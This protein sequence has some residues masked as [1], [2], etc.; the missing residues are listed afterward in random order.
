[1]SDRAGL[2]GRPA[3]RPDVGTALRRGAGS[4]GPGTARGRA[5]RASL[6]RLHGGARRTFRRGR[7]VRRGQRRPRP[8]PGRAEPERCR[9]LAHGG[10]HLHLLLRPGRHRL[11]RRARHGRP[12]GPRVA[13]D[14]ARSPPW[15]IAAMFVGVYLGQLPRSR[16]YAVPATAVAG[17]ATANVVARRLRRFRRS[18]RPSSV[19]WCPTR[20]GHRGWATCWPRSRRQRFVGRAAEI[21]LFR[22]CLD[23]ESPA[24]AVLFVHGPG[25]IGKSSLLDAFAVAGTPEAE[26][27][28]VRLDAR[29][30]AALARGRASGDR[31]SAA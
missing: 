25:G 15:V 8:V 19:G 10:R 13:P 30:L 21:E 23:A 26:C 5:S 18:T 16:W 6:R 31:P 4:L 9:R 7:E 28:V 29:D 27:D 3:D 24:F 22:A 11:G 14:R 17:A 1:M 12:A 20:G 2:S